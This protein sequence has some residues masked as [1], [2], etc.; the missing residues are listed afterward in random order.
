[1]AA[2]RLANLGLRER[3]AAKPVCRLAGLQ[4]AATQASGLTSLIIFVGIFSEVISQ[5][6]KTKM[7]INTTT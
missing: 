5:S 2:N 4:V 3:N 6:N 7:N 1:M